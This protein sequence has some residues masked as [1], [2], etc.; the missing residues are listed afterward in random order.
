MKPYFTPEPAA[1]ILAKAVNL[2]A[3]FSGRESQEKLV[4]QYGQEAVQ[5]AVET[6]LIYP[7]SV[8]GSM[9]FV[10]NNQRG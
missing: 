9:F 8:G 5:A 2:A 4:G 1:A 6:R 7:L 10:T 3:A